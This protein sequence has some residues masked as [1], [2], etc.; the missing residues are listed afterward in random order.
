MNDLLNNGPSGQLTEK[1]QDG[2]KSGN[3]TVIIGSITLG[4]I[5]IAGIAI[6]TIGRSM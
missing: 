3:P 2:I 4:V 6:K 1:I 5:Y